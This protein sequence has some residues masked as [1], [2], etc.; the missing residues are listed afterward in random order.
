MASNDL[1]ISLPSVNNAQ[2]EQARQPGMVVNCPE[3]NSTAVP[4]ES[5][6]SGKAGQAKT[7]DQAVLSNIDRNMGLMTSLLQ[8]LVHGNFSQNPE[9]HTMLASDRSNDEEDRHS[10]QSDGTEADVLS[11]GAPDEEVTQLLAQ[12][13]S[14]AKPDEAEPAQDTPNESPHDGLLQTIAL[15]LAEVEPTGPKDNENLANIA[16]KRWGI[17][18]SNDKLKA[19]LAKHEQ[20]ENCASMTVPKVNPEIWEHLY[21]AKRKSDLRLSNMQQS[22]QH[23]TFALL[24]SCDLLLSATGGASSEEAIKHNVDAIALIGHV[25][26]DVARLP[27][28]QIRPALKAD[29]QNLCAK[30]DD[31]IAQSAWLFGPDLA[32]SVRDAKETCTLSRTLGAPK[33]RPG[34]FRPPRPSYRDKGPYPA[35][36]QSQRG[37]RYSDNSGYKPHFLGKGQKK[38]T[39][40]KRVNKH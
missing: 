20:P 4:L 26:G 15:D 1:G 13:Q 5:S 23:A 7:Q 21:S 3:L 12:Y 22:L 14:H 25:V 32:K 10:V 19:I 16:I 36:S 35:R 37:T 17:A 34:V 28:D 38:P 11:I 18:L 31:D 30:H 40:A 39:R 6:P 33:S 2:P 8:K 9:Q 27:R 29:F 24:K